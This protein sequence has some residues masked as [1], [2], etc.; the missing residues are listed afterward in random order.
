MFYKLSLSVF[1]SVMLAA[2]SVLALTCA[3]DYSGSKSC[4][5][6]VTAAGDC[7][8]LGYSTQNVDGCEHYLYCPFDKAYKKCVDGLSAGGDD[9]MCAGFPLYWCP[10]NA[11]CS[12][13]QYAPNENYNYTEVTRYKVLGCFPGFFWNGRIC[14]NNYTTNCTRNYGRVIEDC[15]GSGAD[16]WMFGTKT[17]SKGCFE[18]L[19]K[20]CPAGSYTYGSCQTGEIDVSTA[21]Y[22]GM[23]CVKCEKVKCIDGYAVDAGLCG[24]SSK[25]W[26]L[27]AYEKDGPCRKCGEC[28]AG[29]SATR[30]T[31]CPAGQIVKEFAN[32]GCFQCAD[33][34]P[35][36]YSQSK[37]DVSQCGTKGYGEKAWK[38]DKK[39]VTYLGKKYT[40]GK[41]TAKT[42][43]D[44]FYVY[45]AGAY[46]PFREIYE[47]LAQF[48]IYS[49]AEGDRIIRSSGFKGAYKYYQFLNGDNAY[50]RCYVIHQGCDFNSGNK[51]LDL[52]GQGLSTK[53]CTA[54]QDALIA[55]CP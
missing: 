32:G 26:Y 1:F 34:C 2:T 22:G 43:A 5:F 24:D 6:N 3:N 36:G 49:D 39:E 11:N 54:A 12:R 29:Y 31:T 23:K 37:T 28:P 4:A 19:P 35:E 17:D 40:C 38:F 52:C 21:Y 48:P 30:P 25:E 45:A 53:G 51:H 55:T 18:C 8:T 41:C 20:E 7:Q 10:E 50:D 14:E 33:I 15:G 44:D 13:C 47:E 46:Y 9:S 42:C 27:S 16:G